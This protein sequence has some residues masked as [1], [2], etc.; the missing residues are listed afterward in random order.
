MQLRGKTDPS[1]RLHFSQGQ[2]AEA[3]ALGCTLLRRGNTAA[4]AKSRAL[5]K[6]IIHRWDLAIFRCVKLTHTAGDTTVRLTH[7]VELDGHGKRAW[8]TITLAQLNGLLDH[9]P[10]AIAQLGAMSYDGAIWHIVKKRQ[11]KPITQLW[12]ISLWGSRCQ[13]VDTTLRDPL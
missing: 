2:L 10:D 4:D 12:I 3:A 7:D 13:F 8:C 9:M 11:N 1:T 5:S 6:P